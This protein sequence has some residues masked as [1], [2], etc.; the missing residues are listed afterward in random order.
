MKNKTIK[1]TKRIYFEHPISFDFKL[2]F[3]EHIIG[4]LKPFSITKIVIITLP[5][6]GFLNYFNPYFL[7][8]INPNN[9]EIPNFFS[10]EYLS[11]HMVYFVFMLFPIFFYF[12]I[13]RQFKK[14]LATKGISYLFDK[15]FVIIKWGGIET[16]ILLSTVDRIVIMDKLILFYFHKLTTNI[17]PKRVF[18]N[19]NELENF[20]NIIENNH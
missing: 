6:I 7:K 5:I 9:P 14:N 17:I 19:K 1:N 18:N 16:K 4:L 8:S 13:K 12:I 20:I 3:K 15:E 10:W 2:S 11:N